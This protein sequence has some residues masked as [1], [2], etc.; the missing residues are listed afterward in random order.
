MQRCYSRPKY[1]SGGLHLIKTGL[2]RE[3]SKSWNQQ[4]RIRRVVFT[5]IVVRDDKTRE[6]ELK[7]KNT[8]RDAVGCPAVQQLV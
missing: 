7:L 2:T 5:L 8:G 1:C 4:L 3:M 6:H